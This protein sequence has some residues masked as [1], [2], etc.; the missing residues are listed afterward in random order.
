MP[1]IPYSPIPEIAPTQEGIPKVHVDAPIAAFGGATAAAEEKLGG[2]ISGVGNE[3][4]ERAYA[5]KQLENETEARQADAQYMMQAGEIHAQFN[6]LEG[7]ARVK[8]FPQYSQNLQDLRVKLRDDL[9]NPMSQ[10]MYDSSS[11]STMGR[12]IFNGAGAA[13]SANKEWVHSVV[14]AQNDLLVK[15]TYD[16]PNDDS[17]YNAAIKNNH[18]TAATRAALTPGGASPERVELMVRQGDSTIAANRVL[19]LARNQ[20]FQAAQL[21]KQYK[22]QGLLF[23]KD[24]EVVS[25][26]VES[27]TETVGTNTI[28][29][30]VLG[31]YLQPDGTYTKPASEMQAEAVELATKSYPDDPKMEVA[32]RGAFDRNFNQHTWAATQDRMAVTQKLNDYIVKGVAST[33]MLPPDLVKQMTPAQIKQFPAQA[34]TYQRS[35]DEQTNRASF[36]KFLGLYNNDNAKFMETNFMSEP[37]LSKSD[38]DRFLKLQRS[39]TP[40]GDPRVSRA[41][42]WLRGYSPG[43]LD[44]LGITGAKKDQDT[45]DRFTGA[46]HDAIQSWQETTGKAPT[47]AQLTKEIYPNLLTRVTEPGWLW[48]SKTE[49]FKSALPK[50]I[51]ERAE[52]AKGEALT[53]E[54]TASLTHDYNR[55]QFNAL[56]SNRKKDQSKP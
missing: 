43:T 15:G 37:G 28:A 23:G 13:A 25:N 27:L 52:K 3:L 55:A 26:K 22:D 10:K 46:L 18:D 17:A 31:K 21:L 33:D 47:E 36:D 8:A 49:F 16:D 5:L 7:E 19:G 32:A 24:E 20:P 41:M 44:S 39:A 1:S 11:L 40:N 54:E 45:A 34:N 53:E 4:F 50:P 30:Q 51:V 35:I 42:T 48:D 9:S 6:A 2:A 56:F 12:S 38:R 14:L 29:N